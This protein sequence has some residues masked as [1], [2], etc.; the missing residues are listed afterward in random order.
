MSVSPP[1]FSANAVPQS[2]PLVAV[3]KLQQLEPVTTV[4]RFRRRCSVSSRF[5]LLHSPH[6]SHCREISTVPPPGTQPA[7]QAPPSCPHRPARSRHP[8]SLAKNGR[9]RWSAPHRY[10]RLATVH[11]HR[12]FLR[13]L[14]LPLR[15]PLPS[16]RSPP[17]LRVRTRRQ[18]PRR[19]LPPST[20]DRRRKA[21][22]GTRAG[23]L[24]LGGELVGR[25]GSEGGRGGDRGD[26]AVLSAE[27]EEAEDCAHGLL[28]WVRLV[29]P[30][31]RPLMEF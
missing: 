14:P 11:R 6:N 31:L 4:P 13:P 8:S 21:R 1:L 12:L 2:L 17:P 18:L 9:C 26:S 24:A 5:P 27:G 25:V 19:A 16:T 23:E 22:L 3:R 7:R 28:D 29:P 10:G 20:R 30:R 15:L